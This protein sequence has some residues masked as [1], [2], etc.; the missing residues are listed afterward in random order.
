[1]AE[2]PR[3]DGGAVDSAGS[4]AQGYYCFY[5]DDGDNSSN[6]THPRFVY[7]LLF[8]FF[9]LPLLFMRSAL[10]CVFQ[11]LHSCFWSLVSGRTIQIHLLA[12]SFQS[13]AAAQRD[14]APL[15]SILDAPHPST[16]H[17]RQEAADQAG[18]PFSSGLPLISF[19]VSFPADVKGLSSSALDHVASSLVHINV[20]SQLCHLCLTSTAA[21]RFLRLVVLRTRDT[22]ASSTGPQPELVFKQLKSLRLDYSNVSDLRREGISPDCFP[23]LEELSLKGSKV[24]LPLCCL[25]S[26]CVCVC[27]F[28]LSLS[29]SLGRSVSALIHLDIEHGLM[30]HAPGYRLLGHCRRAKAVWAP[31]KSGFPRP[32]PKAKFASTLPVLSSTSGCP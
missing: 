6:D 8:F 23:A 26:V 29:L 25:T 12:N 7:A 2:Q 31:Q 13:L 1:M 27:V 16:Q 3:D 32:F 14:L 24:A 17:H 30:C 15:S 9:F 5:E 22:A 28:S 11:N 21:N 4:S 20:A 18:S 19:S 10:D